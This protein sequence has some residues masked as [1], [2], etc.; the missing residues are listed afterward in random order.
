MKSKLPICKLESAVKMANKEQLVICYV[1]AAGNVAIGYPE[2]LYT[3]LQ[4]EEKGGACQLLHILTQ[5]LSL[6]QFLFF[7][8]C[9]SFDSLH[10]FLWSPKGGLCLSVACEKN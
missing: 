2:V 7:C 5:F 6:P 9:G 1:A 10:N 8:P 4:L 3:W